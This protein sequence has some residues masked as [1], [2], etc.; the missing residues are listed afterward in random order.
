MLAAADLV[1]HTHQP[2]LQV[3][4]G[5][6]QDIGVWQVRDAQSAMVQVLVLLPTV[7]VAPTGTV[8][9]PLMPKFE[10][11]VDGRFAPLW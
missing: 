9:E 1:R 3:D 11:M 7:A 4:V 10:L 8:M 5:R 6:A 2:R